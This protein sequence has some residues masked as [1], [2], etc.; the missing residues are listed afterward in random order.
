[1]SD[2]QIAVIGGGPAG[3]VAAIRAAQLGFS[4]VCIE[5]SPTLG[6]TCLNVGCIPS[7]ALLASSEHFHFAAHRFKEHGILTGDLKL[8]LGAMMKRKE[9]VVSRLTKGI[10]FLFKKNKIERKVGTAQLLDAHTIEVTAPDARQTLTAD[11]IILATGSTPVELP[12]MKFDGQQIVDSTGALAFDH[13]PETLLVIGAGAIGLELGSVWARLGSTVTVLEFLPRITAGMD[14]EVSAA[15]QKAFERQGLTFHLNT[16]VQAAKAGKKG[17]TVTA[18]KEAV[19]HTFTAEKVLVAVGRRP[20]TENLGLEAAGVALTDKGRV[21]VDDHWRTTVKNIYAI[22]DLIDGPMLAHKAEDEGVAVAE[23]IAGK[24]GHVNYA[25]IPNVIYTSPEAASV[26]ATEEEL[27]SKGTPYR[28]AKFNYSTN[29]RALAADTSEGFVK[30][31]SHAETDRLLGAHLV[32]SNASELIAEAVVLMEFGGSAEDLA[33]TVHAHPTM[34]EGLKE[35]ALGLD[36]RMI[37]G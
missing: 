34:S 2:F 10:D 1:M 3:Y 37:H 28:V 9:S 14:P 36:G 26:G 21:Q 15:L 35:A 8:D 31:L 22:G 29:G 30:L 5:K 11:H 16:K 33:R 19:E 6:G 7:K 20:C 13:V 23:V 25:C 4:T 17:V 24:A 32:A 12:F 18:M 27:K